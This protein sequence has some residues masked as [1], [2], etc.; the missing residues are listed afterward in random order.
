MKLRINLLNKSDDY[1]NKVRIRL[2]MLGYNF[3][4]Q[5]I[6][7][8]PFVYINPDGGL[9]G[10]GYPVE[11]EQIVY[12][13]DLRRHGEKYKAKKKPFQTRTTSYS[14]KN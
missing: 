3:H 2:L 6:D 13:G 1:R 11:K 12:L 5:Y 14:I 9:V 10:W 4:R 7:K 8:A